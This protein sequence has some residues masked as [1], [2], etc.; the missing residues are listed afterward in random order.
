MTGETY[1]TMVEKTREKN[2]GKEVKKRILFGNYVLQKG[3]YEKYYQRALRLRQQMVNAMCALT[4]RY[5]CLL[6]PTTV[7]TGI[8]YNEQTEPI[9]RYRQ[10]ICTVGANI[11]K[12]PALT[13]PIHIETSA[14]PIGIQL[15]SG[16][17]KENILFA[18]GKRL[19][20]ANGR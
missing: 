15:F 13:L 18:V 5:E 14:I 6:A 10:D 16:V 9:T 2:L 3:Q 19:E 7:T 1:R 17:G 11:A 12:I 4:S 20:E 8:C